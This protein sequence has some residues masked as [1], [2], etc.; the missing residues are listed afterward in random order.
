MDDIAYW[1]A[2]AKFKSFGAV[3]IARLSRHFSSMKNAFEAGTTALLEAGIEPSIAS[4][5]MQERLHIN[6]ELE[7]EKVEKNKIDVI[8]I[9]D[10]RYPTL[11]KQIH[12]PPALLF[13]R[14]SLPDSNLKHL[15]VVGSRKATA[16]GLDVTE[17]VITP[18]AKYGV[19]IVSGLAY[20]ID[21]AAHLT[22][23]EAEGITIAVLGSG[24]DQDSIYPSQN[25][26]LASKI[27]ASGGALVSEFPIGSPP[28]KQNF[29]LRNR[30]IAGMSHGTLVIEAATK[31]GSLITARCALES[32]REVYAVPGSIHATLC[33]GTNDL[34]KQGATPV[35]C[36]S[37]IYATEF[38]NNKKIEYIPVDDEEKKI[39]KI[40][41][42]EPQ[43]I[44]DIVTLS[45][46]PIQ[47]TS[48]ILSLM[49]L[50]GVV[51]HTNGRLYTK[52]IDNL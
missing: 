22:T 48:S 2:I 40:L 41:N 16:Y 42:H 46:L 52:I 36:H 19:V 35:T 50:K 39:Y 45:N 47:T 11:L 7:L 9:N 37:D 27:L 30:I 34:I 14:G 10:S 6:P 12:D 51:S 24:V 23:I 17:S 38:D 8:T 4:R 18:L 28:L 32:N 49:E 25:R 20:G 33:K 1:L 31:S 13:V 5:F 21:A 43:H 26:T 44:D 15:S 3:R 29:P